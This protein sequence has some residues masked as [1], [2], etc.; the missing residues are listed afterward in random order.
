MQTAI[1]NF[2][3]EEEIKQQAQKVA[4]QMGVSLSTIL[5]NYL[6][7]FVKTKAVTFRAD[8][9]IPSEYLM[10]SL[11]RA[12]KDL[13]EGKTSPAF[14]NADDLINYLHKASK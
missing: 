11:E 6:R 3:T 7:Y 2:T 4:K 8:E 12:E 10:Q 14:D 1:I 5:N 9:E 13:K